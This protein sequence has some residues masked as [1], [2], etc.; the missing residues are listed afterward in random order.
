MKC[1]RLEKGIR[2]ESRDLSSINTSLICFLDIWVELLNSNWR[3]WGRRYK[4]GSH[5]YIAMKLAEIP[6][7]KSIDRQTRRFSYWD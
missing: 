4:S 6:R 2:K 5:L 1:V 3:V 7:V